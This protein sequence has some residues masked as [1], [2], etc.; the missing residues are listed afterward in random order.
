MAV[1]AGHDEIVLMNA[2]AHALTLHERGMLAEAEKVYAAIL[3]ASPDHFDALHLLGVLRQQQGDSA[4]AER[5]IGAALKLVPRSVE[6]LCNFGAVLN[7]LKR[8]D[9][10]L[11]AFDQVLAIKPELP[12]ALN[13]RGNTLVQL[14]RLP[15]ALAT[16]DRTLAIK[17]DDLEALISRGNALML[18]NE[19]AQALICFDK[20][21]AQ[22]PDHAVALGNRG[23]ALTRL[24]RHEEALACYRRALDVAPNRL[25]A[26]DSYGS[27]LLALGRAEEALATYDEALA[28]ASNHPIALR[29]RVAALQALG[30][31]AEALDVCDRILAV[32]PDDPETS[33]NRGFSLANLDRLEDAM[34]SYEKARAFGHMAARNML[35][36]CRLATSDWVRAD[37]IAREVRADLAAGNSAN[38]LL[39]T[40]FGFDPATQLEAA[41]SYLRILVP[42]I[43]KPFVHSGAVRAEKLRIA[44][45]TT[46]F[47]KHPVAVA[48]A[49]LL[50]RHD[51]E[52]FEIIGVS[53]GRDDAS[54][55]RSRMVAAL[56]QFH[57]VAAESD[58]NIAQLLNDLKVHIAVDLN[59][60]TDGSRPGIFA[61]RPAPI[62]VSYL[63]YAGTTGSDCIDYILADETVLPFD[64]QRFFSERIV[65]LPD[66]YHANDATRRVSPDVPAR[67]ELGL[68]EQA[69]VF[70]CFN[71]SGK[72]TAPVFDIWMRL[73]ARLPGSVLWLSDLNSLA[74]ANLRR[75]A[76]VRGI[77]PDRMI[78]APWTDR[79]EDHL[80]RYRAA[81]LFLDT[82]PYNGHSTACDALFAGLPV[83]TCLGTTFAGRVG[84]SLLKAAGMSEL[85]TASLE[86]YEALALKLATNRELLSA[87]RRKLEESHATCPLFDNDRFRRG[88]E[89][90]YATMWDIYCRNESPQS[91][92]VEAPVEA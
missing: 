90:A 61:Y 13:Y 3:Q 15:D 72:I 78:V 5:L 19:P 25:P 36:I 56:D 39:A 20:A 26:L 80:T 65:H 38:P 27:A 50:E 6:A 45:L 87:I 88:I 70:C 86:D 23:L 8:P 18:L 74:Q 29:Q 77:D 14:G 55:I 12:I 4:E 33:F 91:F 85:V 59:G 17:P 41:R 71:H 7:A 68:P 51:R 64:Q 9:E 31:H 69:L 62:Q 76:A 75:E 63:G 48:I 11:A 60:W 40:E 89:A 42:V 84:A 67:S 35:G 79:I 73:L 43:P 92:N 53:L 46:A 30:R 57:D 58:R 22:E 34:A 47:R 16:F 10:V 32:T 83:V 49:S 82:L 81:D 44:Y 37:E 24:K 52:R 54:G 21:L 1:P 66:C 28:I 2:T